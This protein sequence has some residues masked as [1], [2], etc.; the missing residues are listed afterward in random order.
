MLN[1]H[2]QYSRKE[3]F[4]RYFWCLK[5]DFL[6]L[7]LEITLLNENLCGLFPQRNYAIE[8]KLLFFPKH[9]DDKTLD[10][11]EFGM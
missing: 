7:F 10:L 6:C 9:D 2:G 3:Q 4:Q 8:Q 1:V 11:N 5:Y